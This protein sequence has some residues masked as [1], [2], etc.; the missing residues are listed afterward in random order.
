[1]SS[2]YQKYYPDRPLTWSILSLTTIKVTAVRQGDPLS[3]P[4]YVCGGDLLQSVINDSLQSGVLRLPIITI[5]PQFPVV[6]YADD[7]ILVISAELD[8]IIA[9]KEIL[10]KFGISTGLKVNFQKSLM[11]NLI[12]QLCLH[13]LW[14]VKLDLCHFHIW[15]YHWAPLDHLFKIWC[16]LFMALTGDLLPLPYFYLKEPGYSLSPKPV[17]EDFATASGLR[18][19]MDKCSANL[20]RCSYADRIIIDQELQCPVVPF[21]LRYLGL[22]L[23]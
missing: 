10:H 8:Q 11:L 18:T 20:I 2:L 13:L 3:P 4:L 12:P 19:N 7:T 22:P 6:Q 15:A 16:Q 17:V 14:V 5:D 9:L 23:T 1:M 21:P